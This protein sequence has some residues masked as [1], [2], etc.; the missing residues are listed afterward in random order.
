[1]TL[2]PWKHSPFE[3]SDEYRTCLNILFPLLHFSTFVSSVCR[4]VRQSTRI[5]YI[6]SIFENIFSFY[7]AASRDTFSPLL[8][9]HE[10]VRW[11]G[12]K[13]SEKLH[14]VSLGKRA[15]V[16]IHFTM[17]YKT[18][19]FCSALR[20]PSGFASTKCETQRGKER[21]P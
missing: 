19:A 8:W 6:F 7:R 21:K 3:P 10:T 9:K 12:E 14:Q 15:K 11:C 4:S 1:M 2:P 16:A 20:S 5:R 17:G 18:F 13:C